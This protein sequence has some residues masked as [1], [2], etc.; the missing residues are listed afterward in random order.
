MMWG[1]TMDLPSKKVHLVDQLV[2]HI[3]CWRCTTFRSLQKGFGVCSQRTS[4]NHSTV[5]T[6]GIR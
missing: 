4:D 2:L 3:I 5:L 1:L 6:K